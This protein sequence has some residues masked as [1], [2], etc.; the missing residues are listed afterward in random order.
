MSRTSG[1][2]KHRKLRYSC[3]SALNSRRTPKDSSHVH[4][5]VD[6]ICDERR[7]EV[8]EKIGGVREELL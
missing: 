1:L 5:I 4:V 2:L 7:Q 8:R 6:R 3:G